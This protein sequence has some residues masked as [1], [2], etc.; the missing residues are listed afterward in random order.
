MSFDFKGQLPDAVETVCNTLDML[1]NDYVDD[2]SELYAES[3]SAIALLR[4]MRKHEWDT[5]Q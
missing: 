5:E 2:E 1:L 4:W 3:M